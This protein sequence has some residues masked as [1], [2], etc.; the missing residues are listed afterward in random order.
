MVTQHI[1]KETFDYKDG[2]LFWKIPRQKIRVGQQAGKKNHNG[3]IHIGFK[4][5]GIAKTFQ[6]HRLIWMWHHGFP[7]PYLDHIDGDPGNNKIENLRVAT[8]TQNQQ[9]RKLNENNTSGIKGVTF[10]KA[11]KKWM[12]HITINK[13]PCYLGIFANKDDA[14]KVVNRARLEFHGEYARFT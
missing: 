13:K 6:E 11:S 7:P 12:A 9:N 10:H 4:I 8:L 3:Y 2:H 5:N 1:L 14:A